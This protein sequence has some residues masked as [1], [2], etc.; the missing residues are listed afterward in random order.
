VSAAR[1]VPV[2]LLLVALAAQAPPVAHA[3][4]RSC[5]PRPLARCFS[6]TVPLDRSGAVAG[7]VRI[8]AARIRSRRA[9]RAPLIGLTGGPGQAGVV[10]AETYDILLGAPNRDL[11]VFDQRGTGASG[12]LRCRGLERRLP[13]SFSSPAG[14][15]GRSLGTRRPFYT[16]ADSAE[17]L[18]ALRVRLGAAQIALYSVSYGTRVALEYARRYPQRVE[19]MI[20]DSPVGLDAPDPLA[21]ETLAA[22]P[23]VIRTA[24]R[25]GACGPAGTHPVADIARLRARLRRTPLRRVV[26]GVPVRVDADDLLGMI[27]GADLDPALMQA[28][29]GAV[30][31]AL[32][33]Q[34]ARLA[35]LKRRLSSVNDAGPVSAFSPALFA[36]TTCE[37]SPAAWDPAAA[38]AARRAQ[39]QA[40]AD[41]T[42]LAVLYPFDR[43][44]AIGAGLLGLCA[45]WPAAARTIVPSPPL[46]AGVPTLVLSGDLDLRTPL[47]KA[48]E[49]TRALPGA[50]LLVERGVG[51]G[52]LGADP[53]G[54]ADG[55]VQ[56]FL[57]RRGVPRC[58]R[59]GASL[60]LSAASAR[61]PR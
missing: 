49:L 58:R 17:D 29:P 5:P 52:V 6:V 54:C 20:L 39:A 21:R 7:S 26:H 4:E 32:R 10:F 19:R 42:P 37:E 15:C 50:R 23:R 45:D 30:H 18:E 56:A 61:P 22:I 44:A 40:L 27:V 43:R 13:T 53:G 12:L 41:A 55:A 14:A 9:T 38:P 1:A 28:I 8:R 24:C 60:S 48:R 34:G 46:P 36:T 33:G 51:H 2:S 57:D 11:V 3:A 47:E 25:G 16:S 31:A 35:R 59:D